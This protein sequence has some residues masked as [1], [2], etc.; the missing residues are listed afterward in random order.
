LRKGDDE[1]KII[2]TVLQ[3]G[4][5]INKE[6]EKIGKKNERLKGK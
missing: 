6:N 2:E 4:G 5:T 1:D 3:E